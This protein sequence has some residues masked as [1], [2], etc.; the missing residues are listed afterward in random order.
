MVE[1]G[2]VHGGAIGLR[3]GLEGFEYGPES[4]SKVVVQ[5]SLRTLEVC[6]N[7]LRGDTGAVL[8]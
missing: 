7:V 2:A 5:A 4:G 1:E 3:S 8:P 6:P